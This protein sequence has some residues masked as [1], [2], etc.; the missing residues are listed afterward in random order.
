[1]PSLA[2]DASVADSVAALVNNN[3]DDDDDDGKDQG[4]C[5][6]TPAQRRGVSDS[7]LAKQSPFWSASSWPA[8]RKPVE[9]PAVRLANSK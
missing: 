5:P 2:A 7:A 8:S 6:T 3:D 4:Q 1:M 9:A